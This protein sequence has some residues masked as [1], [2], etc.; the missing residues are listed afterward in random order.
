MKNTHVD[1]K[2]IK[3]LKPKTDILITSTLEN[4]GI[5]AQCISAGAIDILN[6]PL[7]DEN[8]PL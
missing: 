8:V 1:I 7:N 5:I 3:K 2:N 4:P 6:K